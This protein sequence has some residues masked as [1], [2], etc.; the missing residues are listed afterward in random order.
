MKEQIRINSESI[1][2]N[3]ELMPRK[4]CINSKSDIKRVTLES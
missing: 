3:Q 4:I 1:K 2:Q